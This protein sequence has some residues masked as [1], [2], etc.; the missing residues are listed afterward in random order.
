M[1]TKLKSIRNNQHYAK[2]CTTA[3]TLVH[4]GVLKSFNP[5]YFTQGVLHTNSY[6]LY[7]L[8][9]P[10]NRSVFHVTQMDLRAP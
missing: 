10:P 6:L 1:I 9:K 8:D 3:L 5:F 4:P 7:I 2:I